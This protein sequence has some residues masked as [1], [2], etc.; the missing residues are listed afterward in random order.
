MYNI[1]FTGSEGIQ[2]LIEG[3]DM[4]GGMFLLYISGCTCTLNIVMN[5]HKIFASGHYVTI[6]K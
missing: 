6:N 1:C 4:I 2:I 5:V 3:H